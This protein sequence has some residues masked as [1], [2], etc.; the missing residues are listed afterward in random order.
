MFHGF[1]AIDGDGHIEAFFFYNERKLPHDIR[2][3]VNNDDLFVIHWLAGLQ[4]PSIEYRIV[5]I[6]LDY[7]A[8]GDPIRVSSQFPILAPS[9]DLR[10]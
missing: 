7:G 8:V 1:F 9:F 4:I 10:M 2:F 5:P 6:I 3:V